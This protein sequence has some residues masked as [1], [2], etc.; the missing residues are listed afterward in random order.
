MCRYQGIF[1]SSALNI[2]LHSQGTGAPRKSYLLRRGDAGGPAPCI[3]NLK[4]FGI[5]SNNFS[6]NFILCMTFSNLSTTL[7]VFDK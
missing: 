6:L 1:N 4:N 3:E 2:V 5:K 7:V